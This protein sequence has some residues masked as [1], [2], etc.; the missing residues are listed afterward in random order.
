MEFGPPLPQV[1]IIESDSDSD[2]DDELAD[3]RR[4][5][6]YGINLQDYRRT[7]TAGESPGGI[8]DS[9][10]FSLHLDNEIEL[11]TRVVVGS[12]P[13]IYS[14]TEPQAG[15]STSLREAFRTGQS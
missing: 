6:P 10:P 3:Y 7:P 9:G 1:P 8:S 4:D 12:G 14:A 13:V 5:F 15:T 2:T 11:A